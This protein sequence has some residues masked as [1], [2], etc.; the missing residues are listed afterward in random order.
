ML[1]TIS[2]CFR[3]N[4]HPISVELKADRTK[5]VHSVGE[6]TLTEHLLLSCQLPMELRRG[7]YFSMCGDGTGEVIRREASYTDMAFLL[8]RTMFWEP[9]EQDKMGQKR[10]G[11]LLALLAVALRTFFCM[12]ILFLHQTG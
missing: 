5:T 1:M 3:L 10:L 12:T 2:H 8:S 7:T 11:E 6:Q 9:L 4:L